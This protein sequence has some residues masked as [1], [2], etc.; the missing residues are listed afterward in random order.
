MATSEQDEG[1]DPRR[2]TPLLVA[3][4]RIR[5]SISLIEVGQSTENDT[6]FE[7]VAFEWKAKGRTISVPAEV[8]EAATVSAT[9]SGWGASPPAR[10][11]I[12]RNDRVPVGALGELRKAVARARKAQPKATIVVWSHRASDRL[13]SADFATFRR[14]CLRA[15]VR[16]VSC[17]PRD[18][19]PGLAESATVAGLVGEFIL[20][21]DGE[22]IADSDA[23]C[24]AVTVLNPHGLAPVDMDMV[25]FE[26][27]HWGR[28]R[29]KESLVRTHWG[30]PLVRYYQRLYAIMESSVARRYDPVLVRAFDESQKPATSRG[31]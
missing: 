27:I 30:L 13:E 29:S 31:R 18:G 19:W 16:W 21:L 11:K 22:P 1:N 14:Y 5:G 6:G 7:D 25:E 9:V 23:G 24:S 17:D 15:K 3:L 20:T 10:P 26:R 12:S 2:F 4:S 28:L 8:P